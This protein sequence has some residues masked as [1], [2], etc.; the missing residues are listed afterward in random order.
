MG[1][2]RTGSHVQPLKLIQ[3]DKNCKRLF[4]LFAFED[5]SALFTKPN[6]RTEGR[7]GY[8]PQGKMAGQAASQA[9]GESFRVRTAG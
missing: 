9:G 4:L 6:A 5:F 8:L 7:T 3:I 2:R 1:A